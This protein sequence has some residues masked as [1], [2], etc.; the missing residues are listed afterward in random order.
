VNQFTQVPGL[1]YDEHSA[2]IDFIES[3]RAELMRVRAAVIEIRGYVAALEATVLEL[4][5]A[6]AIT[7]TSTERPDAIAG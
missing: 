3:M 4:R 5:Q 6:I 2:H 7:E 1:T